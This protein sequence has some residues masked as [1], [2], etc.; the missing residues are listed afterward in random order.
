ML[1]FWALTWPIKKKTFPIFFWKGFPL[2]FPES[3][4]KF[5][6]VFLLCFEEKMFCECSQELFLQLTSNVVN[7]ILSGFLLK[8]FSDS[9]SDFPFD[10]STNTQDLPMISPTVWTED[11]PGHSSIAPPK[12]FSKSC[13]E[14]S[15]GFPFRIYS[16]V[17]PVNCWINFSECFFLEFLPGLGRNFSWD[18][19]AGS[20][21]IYIGDFSWSLS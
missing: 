1:V 3:L 12:I 8:I 14:F 20:F 10:N 5:F 9:Y 13:H 6:S 17:S 16:E 11:F 15:A 7:G 18:N 19:F 21:C 2:L 4:V